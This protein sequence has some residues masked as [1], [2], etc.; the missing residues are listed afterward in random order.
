MK[1]KI[2]IVVTI[3][4]IAKVFLMNHI[5]ELKKE[6]DVTLLTNLRDNNVSLE[7]DDISIRHL[8]IERDIKIIRDLISLVQLTIFLKK[9]K[10]D[11]VFS[12]SP[13]AGLLTMGAGWLAGIKTR[14]HI[15]T[16]QVWVTTKGIKRQILKNMDRLISRLASNILVDSKSQRDFLVAEGVVKRNSSS[17]LGSGSICGVDV[18]KFRLD[19]EVREKTR[20]E[21][22]FSSSDVVFIYVGRLKKEK[23]L[24][25]LTSSFVGLLKDY[26]NIKLLIVGPDEEKISKALLDMA[27]QYTENVIVIS[28]YVN[29]P[30]DYIMAADV[31]C[32]PSH[33]EGFGSV[34]IE[35]AASGIP[36]IGSNIYGIRDAIVDNETGILHEVGSIEDIAAKIRIMLNSPS[37]RKEL[38]E[39]ARKRAVEDFSSSRLSYE[40][41]RYFSKILS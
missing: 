27:K 17:V 9:N 23:G 10:F 38:G 16:G 12:V 24:F 13:K 41:R 18:D 4:F 30:G 11:L 40:L 15:F 5:E 33:R 26:K 22:N 31:L 7:C 21:L 20:A 37:F 6:Y 36:A 1:N 28:H 39:N 35:A 19:N 14:A 34:I 2:C 29:N 25:E 3:P 32:L 8:G